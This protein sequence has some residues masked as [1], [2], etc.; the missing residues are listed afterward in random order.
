MMEFLELN[1]AVNKFYELVTPVTAAVSSEAG[2]AYLEPVCADAGLSH[3]SADSGGNKIYVK[4]VRLSDVIK[5][6]VLLLK[7]DVE[8]F[9]DHV[10]K[11]MEELL[12][13]FKIWNII[14]ETKPVGDIAYKISTINRLMVQNYSVFSYPEWYS[15]DPPYPIETNLAEEVLVPLAPLPS[16]G[17]IPFEDLFYTL[18]R[19]ELKW[20]NEVEH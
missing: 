11:G 13:D 20:S 15:A 4:T 3:I 19:Q 2:K 12:R 16:N 6:D 17:W 1:I 14:C 7:I 10:F 5:E 18:Q 9:E 8:G